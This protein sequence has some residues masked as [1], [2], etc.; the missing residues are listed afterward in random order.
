MDEREYIR[1]LAAEADDT[2]DMLS[3]HR[4]GERERGAVAAFLRC[5]GVDFSACELITPARDPPDVIFRGARF[6]V[7]I[8]LDEGRK[9]HDDWKK[10]ADQR[11]SAQSLEELFEPYRPRA[12][13]LQDVIPLLVGR[14]AQ[15]ASHYGPDTCSQLDALVYI[16]FLKKGLCRLSEA[17]VP[18]E[19]RAQ[20]W[21]SVC[22]L[23]PP[24]SHVLAVT[25]QSPEF[26]RRYEGSTRQECQ[27]WGVM[28]DL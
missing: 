8:I 2:V 19:L 20:H 24:H 28:F 11:H 18:E 10:K 3:S 1:Q 12:I 6:E 26:L 5:F 9:M 4:K 23:F 7:M 17:D 27:N 13:A 15:K 21:R 25:A 16:N 22:F 14:L